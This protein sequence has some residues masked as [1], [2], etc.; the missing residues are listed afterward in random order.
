MG[1]EATLALMGGSGGVSA[2]AFCLTLT[3]TTNLLLRMVLVTTILAVSAAA[4]AVPLPW[5]PSSVHNSVACPPWASVSGVHCVCDSGLRCTRPVGAQTVSSGGCSGA[6]ARDHPILGKQVLYGFNPALCP[7]CAC[8]VDSGNASAIDIGSTI[9]AP[10]DANPSPDSGPADAA[11]SDANPSPDSGP[12]DAAGSEVR[13]TAREQAGAAVPS[14]VCDRASTSV[15][16]DL[17]LQTAQCLTTWDAMHSNGIGAVVQKTLIVF[18][19]AKMLGIPFCY[20]SDQYSLRARGA[21]QDIDGYHAAGRTLSRKASFAPVIFRN[22]PRLRRPNGSEYYEAVDDK[23]LPMQRRADYF[24]GHSWPT[25]PACSCCVEISYGC[26]FKLAPWDTPAPS[27]TASNGTQYRDIQAVGEATVTRVAVPGLISTEPGSRRRYLRNPRWRAPGEWTATRAKQ[28]PNLTELYTPAGLKQFRTGMR[29]QDPNLKCPYGAGIAAVHLRRGDAVHENRLH[30]IDGFVPIVKDVAA[31][32][33]DGTVIHIFSEGT[34]DEFVNLTSLPFPINLV[35]G[36]GPGTY[37]L[38]SCMAQAKYLAISESLFSSTAAAMSQAEHIWVAQEQIG[39]IQPAS[40]S[41]KLR[42]SRTTE[43]IKRKG[44]FLAAAL[45]ATG[46]E[47]HVHAGHALEE[48]Q[49]SRFDWAL[50]TGLRAKAAG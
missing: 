23:D 29:F 39:V 25:D 35:L 36:D 32:A 46:A 19:R 13:V 1:S 7:E 43:S 3:R 40:M 33:P 22:P 10:S 20:R 24:A 28:S 47:L 14:T 41:N 26:C 9:A 8:A 12:A 48:D 30:K 49:K 15:A 17:E 31:A 38:H 2:D 21:S 50:G 11:P 42:S 37:K 4:A 6:H 5:P 16:P 18:L 27:D 45:K 44:L 34:P